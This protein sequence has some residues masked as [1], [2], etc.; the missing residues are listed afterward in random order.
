MSIQRGISNLVTSAKVV[1]NFIDNN[2]DKNKMNECQNKAISS[3]TAENITTARSSFAKKIIPR[4]VKSK[5]MGM[6][7]QK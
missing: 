2:M 5:K 1:N 6:I 4:A 3:S 7:K